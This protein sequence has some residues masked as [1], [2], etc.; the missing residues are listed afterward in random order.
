MDKAEIDASESL[1]RSCAKAEGQCLN[2][3]NRLKKAASEIKQS[4]TKEQGQKKLLEAAKS[5]EKSVGKAASE[6]KAVL[7][8]NQ[9]ARE[10]MAMDEFKAKIGKMISAIR[11]A[12]DAAA[13]YDSAWKAS[14]GA[15]WFANS[16]IMA[17]ACQNY[18]EILEDAGGHVKRD[19]GKL[20]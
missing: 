4:C 11:A 16:Y 9:K 14:Q 15:G 19:F 7:K 20:K 5:L 12:C 1:L 6:V 10:A 17:R 18:C 13:K 2:L 3:K 8:I